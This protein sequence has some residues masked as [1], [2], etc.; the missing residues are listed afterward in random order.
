M[1]SQVDLDVD[2]LFNDTGSLNQDSLDHILPTADHTVLQTQT[3][4][5]SPGV[6]ERIL[7]L[8]YS[9]CLNRIAWSR[10]GHIAK[11]SDDGSTVTL[12]CLRADSAN[13][14]WK[15]TDPRPLGTTYD[16]A[17]T[18]LWSPT[19]FDLAVVDGRG[20]VFLLSLSTTGLNLLD[21]K[22][23]GD[24]DEPDELGQP[25]GA[26]WFN[27]DRQEKS[28]SEIDCKRQDIL[29]LNPR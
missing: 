28:V 6:V 15:L 27:Q 4:T 20:R 3:A 7:G 21:E 2:N 25:I 22:K 5:L 11:I 19:G 17:K 8:T 1:D 18:L 12:Q 23:S 9:G 16:A 14:K 10:Q 29:P 24:I 26:L 13:G